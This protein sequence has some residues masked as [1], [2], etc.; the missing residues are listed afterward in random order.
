MKDIN[1]I[2]TRYLSV[3]KPDGIS[4]NEL[5]YIQTH[6][7]IVLPNDFKNIATYFSGGFV[8]SIDMYDFIDSDINIIS[9]TLRLRCA[10]DLPHRFVVLAELSES[11]VI[12]DTEQSPSVIWCDSC[13]A[14]NIGTS[15]YSI[16][17]DV[18]DSYSDFFADMVSEELDS[19][20]SEG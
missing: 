5:N 13:D 7:E 14:E 17:P 3:M 1:A 12:M 8:G 6:L 15:E 16:T 9:E 20:V 10:I 18:W 19:Y 11:L 2:R 4:D